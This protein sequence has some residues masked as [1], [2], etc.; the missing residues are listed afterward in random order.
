MLKTYWHMGLDVPE[1]FG[2]VT[3]PDVMYDSM[4]DECSHEAVR[5]R[6]KSESRSTSRRGRSVC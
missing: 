5:W 4:Y 6:P 3:R 1:L 2:F